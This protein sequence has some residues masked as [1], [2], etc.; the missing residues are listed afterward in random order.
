MPRSDSGARLREVPL[1]RQAFSA[2][3]DHF[4]GRVH[5]YVSPR[6]RDQEICERIVRE[7]LIAHID[8]LVERTDERRQ[9]CSIKVFSDRLIESEDARASKASIE[10]LQEKL[11][12]A[13]PGSS[14]LGDLPAIDEAHRR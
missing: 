3:F 8:L 14:G 2:R 10:K 4:F 7:V 13:K 12:T 5:A 1:T 6:V 11:K 9:L